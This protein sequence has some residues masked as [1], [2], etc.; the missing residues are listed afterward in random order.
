[1]SLY[2]VAKRLEALLALPEMR[3]FATDKQNKYFAM[4]KRLP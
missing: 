1:M 3:R 4:G 2:D